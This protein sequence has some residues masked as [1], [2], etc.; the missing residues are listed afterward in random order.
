MDS[1]AHNHEHHMM[2]ETKTEEGSLKLAFSATLHCLI[3]C[4]LGEVVGMILATW[5]GW[6]N[7]A[8]IAL[9]V[10]LGFVFGFVLGMWPLLRAKMSF[11]KAFR[12]ILVAEG[13]SILVMETAEVLVQVYSP[14]VMEASLTDGI[15]WLGMF[16]ALV[17]GF[18]AALPIN[19]ILVR[20][21]VRHQH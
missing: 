9:A 16:L 3:G 15:F 13:V 21:G 11:R 20:R 14:G 10:S 18:L 2:A 1:K 6:G 4:G 17:A 19:I 12:I 8:S 7:V 5:W